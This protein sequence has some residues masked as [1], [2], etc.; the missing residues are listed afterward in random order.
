M[1]RIERRSDADK[2]MNR[3]NFATYQADAVTTRPRPN[4]MCK[5]ANAI[6]APTLLLNGELSPKF[7]HKVNDELGACLPNHERAIVNGSSHT[8]PSERSESFN[9][10]VLVFFSKY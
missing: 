8:V 2:K 4:F 3:D 7:F 1:A 9:E 10:A 6:V 5:M